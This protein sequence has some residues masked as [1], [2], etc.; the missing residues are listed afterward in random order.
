MD[1]VY[2]RNEKTVQ[3]RS[4]IAAAL[5]EKIDPRI[6]IHDF[7]LSAC[8]PGTNV[9]FDV[10]IPYGMNRT[11]EAILSDIHSAI[12]ALDE[13]LTPIVTIEHSYTPETPQ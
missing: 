10:V 3:L 8:A 6:T 4:R 11:D 9:L 13:T 12:R 2:T 5:C 7:R 1:P